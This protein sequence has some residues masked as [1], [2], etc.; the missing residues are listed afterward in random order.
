MQRDQKVGLALGVLLIGTV[1]AFFFRN[2]S[3]LP[4]GL[5]QLER[6][7][8]VDR[9]IAEKKLSPY[10]SGIETDEP[11][12][13]SR[14][15]P[16]SDSRDVSDARTGERKLP[17]WEELQ[18]ERSDPFADSS[19]DQNVP[20]PAPDP[21]RFEH[22]AG[23]NATAVK[24]DHN[25][26]WNPVEETVHDALP[27]PA[28]TIHEVQRG[29]TLSSIAG[30]YLGS[31]A[32]FHEIYEANKDQLR[33]ANDLK[34]GMKLKIPESKSKAATSKALAPRG[35]KEAGR[36]P[37]TQP[38]E[39]PAVEPFAETEDIFAQSSDEENAE[40]V[41]QGEEKQESPEPPRV[42]FTPAKRRSMR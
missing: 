29:D 22:A 30:K 4:T 16:A 15:R 31:Q 38:A 39:A 18:T 26:A 5:P 37:E 36:A 21:I 27:A 41:V 9:E 19:P 33:D 42:K 34:I 24:L 12:K 28:P 20:T 14:T 1:A 11:V 32:R 40:A 23:E 6:A 2:E 35:K 8:E 25:Q 7:A 13:R 10:L 3:T 17:S